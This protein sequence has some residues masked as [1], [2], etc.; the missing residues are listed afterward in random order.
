MATDIHS[1]EVDVSPTEFERLGRKL[2]DTR[3]QDRGIVPGAG[4]K[5]DIN[6]HFVRAHANEEIHANAI[7]LLLIY[8]W[9]GSFYKLSRVW[10]PLSHPGSDTHPTFHVV[11]VSCPVPAGLTCRHAR[12]GRS[13]LTHGCLMRDA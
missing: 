11:I 1:F 10:H 9:Q 5:Y 12:G 6:L 3:I 8:G 13:R 7:P 2:D 4:E